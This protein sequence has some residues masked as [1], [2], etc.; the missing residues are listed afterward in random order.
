MKRETRLVL[1]IA[2]LAITI[3]AIAV[4]TYALWSGGSDVGGTA[5]VDLLDDIT[6]RYLVLDGVTSAGKHFY[7]TYNDAGYFTYNSSYNIYDEEVDTSAT[8]FSYISVIG[9]TGSLGEFESLVI[10]DL[11]S[12]KE[13]AGG[14]GQLHIGSQI[15]RINMQSPAAFPSLK[16]IKS[17]TIGENVSKIEGVSFSFWPL[18]TDV[19][20][21]NMT[22][23]E[24]S[25]A[26]LS[27]D[28]SAN[29]FKSSGSITMHYSGA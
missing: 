6:Y 19:Y 27:G 28:V 17:V 5:E 21:K 9:Y 22:S 7:M 25:A 26:V 20:F 18:L 23:S 4:P 29:A 15:T 12:W 8:T 24:Y 13:G 1:I 14:D 11:I 10:P 2:L 16:G 3:I